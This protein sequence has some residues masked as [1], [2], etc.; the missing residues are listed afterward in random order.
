MLLILHIFCA[1]ICHIQYLVPTCC[2]VFICVIN[3]CSDVFQSQFLSI[4]RE[5][6]TL[7]TYT[8]FVKMCVEEMDCI[9]Q[10]LNIIKSVYCY[11]QFKLFYLGIDI[12]CCIQTSVLL[13]VL[14]LNCD[15]RSVNMNNYK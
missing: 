2:T 15:T 13:T 10:C 11:I 8:A 7:S 5:V 1:A 14:Q 9:H 4:I 12:L 3:Y 6:A